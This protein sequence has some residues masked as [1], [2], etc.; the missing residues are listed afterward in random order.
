MCSKE[1]FA[2]QVLS[3][4]E[5]SSV[6]DLGLGLEMVDSYQAILHSSSHPDLFQSDFLLVAKWITPRD[7]ITHIGGGAGGGRGGEGCA[8][9]LWLAFT[10]TGQTMTWECEEPKNRGGVGSATDTPSC[11]DISDTSFS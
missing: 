1:N 9:H 7:E 8:E 4:G 6:E 11:W 10:T 5:F 2:Q 3:Q